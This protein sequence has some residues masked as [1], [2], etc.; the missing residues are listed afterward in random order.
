MQTSYESQQQQQQQQQQNSNNYVINSQTTHSSNSNAN[1]MGFNPMSGPNASQQTSSAVPNPNTSQ[2]NNNSTN[3]GN[4][5]SKN[6]STE[7]GKKVK[8]MLRMAG[9][10][11][12]E[13]TSLLEWGNDD[14]RIFCGDLGNDVTDDVLA[15][16]F[17]R[18]SSFTK[19][20]VIRDKRNNK[21]KGYGFVSFKD[22]QDFARAIKE[23]NG[24]SSFLFPLFILKSEF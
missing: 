3:S 2:T 11:I 7:K 22:P 21:S 8:K 9:G 23:M 16:A 20:K 10:T 24:L 5:K 4:K 13:D 15:R 14:F 17:N 6:N 19:A 12:W 1:Q 18:F